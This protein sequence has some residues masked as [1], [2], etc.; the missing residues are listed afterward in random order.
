VLEKLADG[1]SIRHISLLSVQGHEH[2]RKNPRTCPS[3]SQE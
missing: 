3:S 2:F 1:Q